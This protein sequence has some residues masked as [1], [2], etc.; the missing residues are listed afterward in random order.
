M[1]K[2]FYSMVVNE[3]KTEFASTHGEQTK[4]KIVKDGFGNIHIT[5]ASFLAVQYSGRGSRWLK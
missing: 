5:L 2:Y 4:S 3:K 1:A